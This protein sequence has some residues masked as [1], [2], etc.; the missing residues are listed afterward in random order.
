MALLGSCS[1]HSAQNPLQ[2]GKRGKKRPSATSNRGR[3]KYMYIDIYVKLKLK[4]ER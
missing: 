4:R 3:H 1:D 2:K